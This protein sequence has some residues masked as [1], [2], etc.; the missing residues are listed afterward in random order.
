MI[1]LPSSYRATHPTGGLP[2][3]P[4]VDVFGKPGEQ[5]GAPEAGTVRR[6]SG[7]DPQKGGTPG[8]PYGW[9]IY[10]D[11]PSGDYYL[12]HFG[13]RKVKVGQ[14]VKRGEIIGTICNS[15]VSGKP[16][17]S[18]IH[19]GKKAK[20]RP[21]PEPKE[22]LYRVVGPKKG[23]VARRKNAAAIGKALPGWV[24]RFGSVTVLPDERSL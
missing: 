4:A 21:K 16:G 18:H 17:T 1:V 11:C 24:K 15:A 8:G 19:M 7:K 23:N 6:L 22:R 3:Y 13:S 12:T 5:V 14:K 2:G 9:S 10:L 20:A